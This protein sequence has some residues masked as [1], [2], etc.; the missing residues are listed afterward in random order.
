MCMYQYS[1]LD[2]SMHTAKQLGKKE[3]KLLG[4]IGG[5]EL[6]PPPKEHQKKWGGR[7][8]QAKALRKE[9]NDFVKRYAF[10]IPPENAPKMPLC[11]KLRNY[12]NLPRRISMNPTG[13]MVSCF[14]KGVSQS[15]RAKR[16]ICRVS[17]HISIDG[18]DG[19][20]PTRD[21]FLRTCDLL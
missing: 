20:S 16:V 12:S 9:T 2:D 10:Y 19:T 15:S 5:A 14:L 18:I 17:L 8:L 1:G 13:A 7:M 11:S 21:L 3:P 6:N 4:F